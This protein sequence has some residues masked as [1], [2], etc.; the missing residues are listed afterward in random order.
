MHVSKGVNNIN[1][2]ACSRPTLH[3]TFPPDLEHA[4]L[5][6]EEVRLRRRVALLALQRGRHRA[7]FILLSKTKLPVCKT[8]FLVCNETFQWLIIATLAEQ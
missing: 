1:I 5:V 4:S 8:N 6:S 7:H 2:H 3:L